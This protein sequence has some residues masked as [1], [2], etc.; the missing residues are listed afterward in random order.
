VVLLFPGGHKQPLPVQEKF[1]IAEAIIQ[2][3]IAW[4]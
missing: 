4:G 3:V 1:A 2:Q